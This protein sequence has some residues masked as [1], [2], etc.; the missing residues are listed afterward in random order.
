VLKGG[1]VRGM[2]FFDVNGDGVRR[3]EP[4][5]TGSRVYADLNGNGRLDANEPSTLS[6]GFGLYQLRI[7]QDGTYQI[8]HPL[9]PRHLQTK[10]DPSPVTL[11]GGQVL[12]TL[13][14]GQIVGGLPL[15][16]VQEITNG[17][18][19]RGAA[20]ADRN[21]NRKRDPGENGLAGV[22]VFLD[23]NKNGRLDR[24]EV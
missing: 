24:G 21:G 6:D 4:N 12:G 23:A 19:V 17:G 8:R 5:F 13:R 20:Y 14:N 9:P 2:T 1:T 15:F 3:F 10:P 11:E 22:T 18:S 7:R 16:G